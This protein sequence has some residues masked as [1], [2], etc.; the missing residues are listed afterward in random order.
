MIKILI[1][2]IKIL[3]LKSQ[4]LLFLILAGNIVF[5]Q[6][7]VSTES[8]LSKIQ[9]KYSQ[10]ITKSFGFIQINTEY[11]PN[12]QVIGSTTYFKAIKIP[13]QMRCDFGP[14]IGKDGY[15][16]SQGFVHNFKEGRTTTKE[17]DTKNSMLLLY[18][19][20]SLTSSVTISKLTKMGYNVALF[21]EDIWKGRNVYVIGADAGDMNSNQFWIDQENLYLVRN[22]FTDKITNE[23]TEYQY[24][25]HTKIDDAWLET[26][27]LIFKNNI[28][29][30]R[31][32]YTDLIGNPK[33]LKDNLFMPENWISEH[34]RKKTQ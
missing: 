29:V 28:K 12:G 7:L 3:K 26:E 13:S 5:G 22:I 1:N 6:S 18:D 4:Y 25:E 34:W 24:P 11:N 27:V 23:Q 10:N 19:L 20:Q 21:R 2:N 17:Y 14:Q 32:R 9:T 33:T 8:L 30:R 16:I 31:E 15:L